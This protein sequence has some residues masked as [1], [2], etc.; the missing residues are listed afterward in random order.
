MWQKT[1]KCVIKQPPSK[2]G[3]LSKDIIMTIQQICKILAVKGVKGGVGKTTF[4]TNVAI[5]FSVLKYRTALIDLD[6]ELG[7]FKLLDSRRLNNEAAPQVDNYQVNSPFELQKLMDRLQ[8]EYE[9]IIFDTPGLDDG[10]T[11]A[12]L[13][14][15][16]LVICPFQASLLDLETAR[17][18]DNSLT[19]LK[20]S[21]P[22]VEIRAIINRLTTHHSKRP[23]KIKQVQDSFEG[24][25][26]LKLMKSYLSNR[27][28]FMD[29]LDDDQGVIE[30]TDMKAAEEI[31]D[32]FTEII[33]ILKGKG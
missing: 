27:D 4:T 9:V 13:R 25:D 14:Y 6:P 3:I 29:S 15:C 16:D 10:L 8:D 2:V 7:V 5:T 23:K 19:K 32:V 33:G 17:K 20:A 1:S 24:W 22:D 21:N 28:A 31:K 26:N 18:V 30:Y 12:A 11:N